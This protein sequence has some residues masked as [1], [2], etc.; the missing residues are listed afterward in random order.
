MEKQE[1]VVPFGM[2]FEEPATQLPGLIKPIYDEETA[3][4]YAV[5]NDGVRV[6]FVNLGSLGTD[7][8]TKQHGEATDSDQQAFGGVV[9]TQTITEVEAEVTDSDIDSNVSRHCANMST[10]TMTLSIG[11]N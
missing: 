2:L 1:L 8:F 6:P 7:M 3:L 9:A 4:S 5:G 10:N 11:I